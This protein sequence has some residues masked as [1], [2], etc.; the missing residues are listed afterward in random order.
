MEV[1]IYRI[2]LHWTEVKVVQQAV[3]GASSFV[4]GA[5]IC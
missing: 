2:A 3:C 4:N 1:R 5:F